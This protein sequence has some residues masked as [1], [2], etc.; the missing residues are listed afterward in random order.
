MLLSINTESSKWK[1][2]FNFIIT[3]LADPR[4]LCFPLK[5]PTL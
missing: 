1:Y 3:I 5:I 2:I 4:A